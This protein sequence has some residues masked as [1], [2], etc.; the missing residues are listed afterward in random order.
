MYREDIMDPWASLG[1]TGAAS[2]DPVQTYPAN[3][4]ELAA[5]GFPAATEIYLPGGPASGDITGVVAS[6]VL[7]DVV[8]PAYRQAFDPTAAVLGAGFTVDTGDAFKAANATFHDANATAIAFLTTV[9]LTT[10]G[11]SRDILGKREPAGD[12]YGYELQHKSDASVGFTV[13]GP[14]NIDTKYVTPVSGALAYLC[15]GYSP[16]RDE[17]VIKTKGDKVVS[18][19]AYTRNGNTTNT[20]DFSLG[21]GKLFTTNMIMGPTYIWEGAGAD[22][23]MASIDAICDGWWVY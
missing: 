13:K 8:T 7:A 11:T 19:G 16:G 21:R 22:T 15:C 6:T 1:G 2:E 17:L 10:P 3:N 12:G 18:A 4:T 14:A 5:A 9:I 20:Q 23:L